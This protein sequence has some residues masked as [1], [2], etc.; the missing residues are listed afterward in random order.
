MKWL[1]GLA[2]VAW[3]AFVS[4]SA[5]AEE[6]KQVAEV[7][8]ARVWLK[9]PN[10]RSFEVQSLVNR[11]PLASCEGECVVELPLGSYWVTIPASEGDAAGT[12]RLDVSGPKRY[13][14]IDPDRSAANGGRA[15][16]IVGIVLFPVAGV[17]FLTSGVLC[18]DNCG[19]PSASES[20]M[21][22]LSLLSLTAGA[23]LTPVGWVQYARNRRPKLEP[24]SW[25]ASVG[26][27]RDGVFGV[28]GRF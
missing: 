20:G 22:W 12:T 14:L 7:P 24:R 26:V 13:R 19:S 15:M 8:T 3:G 21:A 11:Q 23:V 9:A 25:D 16:G 18:V 28:M 17:L 10:T 27:T 4:G 1:S 5:R 6:T 2:V